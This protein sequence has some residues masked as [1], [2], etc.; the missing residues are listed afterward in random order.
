MALAITPLLK[1]DS[2]ANTRVAFIVMLFVTLAAGRWPTVAVSKSLEFDETFH[3]TAALTAI[4]HPIPWKSFDPDTAGPLNVYLLDLPRL[5]GFDISYSTTHIITILLLGGILACLFIF[6]RCFVD[7]AVARG[8]VLPSLIFLAFTFNSEF[9]HY[10]SEIPSLFLLALAAALATIAWRNRRSTIASALLTGL[11]L[12]AT[13]F[14]K[15]QSVP[16]AALGGLA[17]LATVPIRSQVNRRS[18]F[19]AFFIGLVAFPAALLSVVAIAGAFGDF[20]VSY[21]EMPFAYVAGGQQQSFDF[22]FREPHFAKLVLVSFTTAVVATVLAFTLKPVRPSPLRTRLFSL[23]VLAVVVAALYAVF[24]PH[25]PWTHY[26]FFLVPALVLIVASSLGLLYAR[27]ADERLRPLLLL[28][29]MAF[30]LVPLFEQSLTEREPYIGQIAGAA[31]AR[32]GPVVSILQAIL[33]PGDRLAVW[34]F[35][36]DLFPETGAL[37]G[38]RDVNPTFEMVPSRLTPYYRTRYARDMIALR[39]RAFVDAVAPGAVLYTDRKTAGFETFPALAEIIRTRYHLVCELSGQ[40]IFEINA[41]AD[42]TRVPWLTDCPAPPVLRALSPLEL[43]R[44]AEVTGQAASGSV[45]G[46]GALG[47]PIVPGNGRFPYGQ[48]ITANGWAVDPLT[49]LPGPTLLFVVDG[50][51]RT[52]ASKYYGRARPDIVSALGKLPSEYSGFVNAIIAPSDL[53]RGS[54]SVQV[55]IVTSDGKRFYLVKQP[56]Y[57][58]IY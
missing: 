39:P 2:T 24:E 58:E 49:L 48:Q 30:M 4:A 25:R 52:D 12:G 36:Q 45:D 57:F 44:L 40:R 21:L 6:A 53:R 43:G 22:I 47:K 18:A 27:L 54:H 56:A 1:R 11:V 20:V 31:V 3:L 34:G 29:A 33:R 28:G 37:L 10:A 14:A 15:L 42:G 13:P 5:F 26:L 9:M 51:I 32:P 41:E 50:R 23:S 55:G 17:F 19:I 35:D 8:S 7:E 16:L 46:L 38:T